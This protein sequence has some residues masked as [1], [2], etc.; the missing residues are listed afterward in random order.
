VGGACDVN[1]GEKERVDIIG[2]KA[3][4]KGITRKSNA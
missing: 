1:G 4:E 2:R 3:R